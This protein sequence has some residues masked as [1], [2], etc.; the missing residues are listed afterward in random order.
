MQQCTQIGENGLSAPFLAI[1]VHC[2][3]V[4]CDASCDA[5][6]VGWHERLNRHGVPATPHRWSPLPWSEKQALREWCR[7]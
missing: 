2:W 1:C 4:S 3:A 5:S 6:C 7:R